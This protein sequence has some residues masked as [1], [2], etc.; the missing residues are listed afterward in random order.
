MIHDFELHEFFH[1][2]KNVYLEALLYDK[3]LGLIQAE[4]LKYVYVYN[5]HV[6]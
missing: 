1:S 2:P 4:L 3:V 6:Y 5:I